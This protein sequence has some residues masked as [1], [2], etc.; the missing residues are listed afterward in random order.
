MTRTH[1]LLITNQLLYQLSYT[2]L[3]LDSLFIL[4]QRQGK[5]KIFYTYFIIFIGH[6]QDTAR[7]PVVR[8]LKINSVF[9]QIQT[10]G[11]RCSA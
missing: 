5:V 7:F 9:P 2:S 4:A 8:M 3:L 6:Y 10:P 1:D 11:R